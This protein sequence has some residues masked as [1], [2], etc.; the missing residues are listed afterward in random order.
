MISLING[1]LCSALKNLFDN[2]SD[3]FNFTSQT[4]QTEWNLT[5]HL[6][7]EIHKYIFWLNHDL[8][9]MK[10]NVGNKR[11]DIIFHKREINE[12]NFLV[13]EVKRYASVEKDIRKIQEHWMKGEL[14][15]RFG[16]NIKIVSKDKYE[17]IIFENNGRKRKGDQRTKYLPIGVISK[18]EQKALITI[19]DTI[20]S[21]ALSE[22]Y[23][24]NSQ[25]QIEVHKY[26]CQIDQLVHKL[27]E[28]ND[29]EIKIVEG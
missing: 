15:Y 14:K 13:V 20:H 28:L 18:Q 25:K 22:D 9:V 17:V 21:L 5:H 26:E 2:Q 12:L 6:A 10:K 8:D 4:G 3:I 23:L 16:A 1:I 11:P 19:V 27:Y 24:D 29:E 7:N